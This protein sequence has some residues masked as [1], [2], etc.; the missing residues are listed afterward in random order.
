MGTERRKLE[1]LY[2]NAEKM[3]LKEDKNLEF[4]FSFF[5]LQTRRRMGMMLLFSIRSI[6]SWLDR[7][8]CVSCR[9]ILFY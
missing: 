9:A 2:P 3:Q 7:G 1:Y 5:F 8:R 6:F 4:S